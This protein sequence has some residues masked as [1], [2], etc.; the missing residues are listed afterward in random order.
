MPAPIT[1]PLSTLNPTHSPFA[2][3]HFFDSRQMDFARRLAVNVTV[4]SSRYHTST[5]QKVNWIGQF[6]LLDKR[7]RFEFYHHDN[8]LYAG[9]LGGI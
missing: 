5:Y 1:R 8:L 7:D 4:Q 3:H 6:I 9:V 2:P